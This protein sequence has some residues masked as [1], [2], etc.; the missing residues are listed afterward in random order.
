[1]KKN[2]FTGLLQEGLVNTKKLID[3]IRQ[4]KWSGTKK[5]KKEE[6]YKFILID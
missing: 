1:M 5:K 2:I 3:W 4:E 6:S